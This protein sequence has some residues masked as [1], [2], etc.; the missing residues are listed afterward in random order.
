MKSLKVAVINNI[1]YCKFP[2]EVNDIK[3]FIEFL[4]KN[5]NSF[6]ELE[7]LVEE[8]CV[9]PFFIEEDLKTE[10]QYWNASSI[11]LVKESEVSIL[12]RWEYEEK[13]KKVIQEKCVHCIYYSEEVCEENLKSHIE[14]IDLIGECYGFE[15]KKERHND[16]EL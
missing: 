16:N 11:R 6:F 13:L 9:A 14:H 1:N 10:T 12:R 4:N 3:E 8:G 7:F 2:E 5:Y 15:Q